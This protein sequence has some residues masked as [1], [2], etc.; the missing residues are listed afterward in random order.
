V[1]SKHDAFIESEG[2]PRASVYVV[3]KAKLAAMD[4]AYTGE[5]PRDV[6]LRLSRAKFTGY[7]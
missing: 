4:E 6:V 2:V 3:M 5:A 1:S 7:V